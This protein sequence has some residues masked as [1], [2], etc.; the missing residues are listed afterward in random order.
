VCKLRRSISTSLKEPA[1]QTEEDLHGWFFFSVDITSKDD[2]SSRFATDLNEI[3]CICREIKGVTQQMS[4]ILGN[5]ITGGIQTDY[6]CQQKT[7]LRSAIGS[8][9]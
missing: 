6:L 2:E 5:F 9:I 3:C 8:K 4:E 1:I 7:K